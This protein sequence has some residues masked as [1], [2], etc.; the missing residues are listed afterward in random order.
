MPLPL[1]LQTRERRGGG[2]GGG[3][4]QPARSNKLAGR[5]RRSPSSPQLCDSLS[6][7]LAAVPPSS[8][9]PYKY[10]DVFRPRRRPTCSLRVSMCNR[11]SGSVS[12]SFLWFHDRSL[13]IDITYLFQIRGKRKYLKA[14]IAVVRPIR[15]VSASRDP[16][17]LLLRRKVSCHAWTI[18]LINDYH[19]LRRCFTL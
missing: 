2:G 9:P 10:S 14:M 15:S 3:G 4:Q 19:L 8:P 7:S 5:R 11:I 13:I 17:S 16:R 1:L 6:C 18:A 12:C